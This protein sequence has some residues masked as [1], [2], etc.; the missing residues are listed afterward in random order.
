MRCELNNKRTSSHYERMKRKDHKATTSPLE[1]SNSRRKLNIYISCLEAAWSHVGVCWCV[2]WSTW[3][4]LLEELERPRTTKSSSQTVPMEEDPRNEEDI[5]DD[6]LCNPLMRGTGTRQQPFVTRVSLMFT[7]RN[8]NGRDDSMSS[9]SLSSIEPRKQQRQDS[10]SQQPN[11]Q[12]TE[13]PH[14]LLMLLHQ[15]DLEIKGL[16]STAQRD[17]SDRLGCILQELVKSRQKGSLKRSPNQEQLQKEVE[18]LNSELAAI[19]KSH[20]KEMQ[21][22]ED[23][24]MK[25]QL[26]VLH[27]QET[28]KSLSAKSDDDSCSES[29]I[30]V[31]EGT[32]L[33]RE[34][35]ELWSESGTKIFPER[36]DLTLRRIPKHISF[37]D[38]FHKFGSL[39]SSDEDKDDEVISSIGSVIGKAHVC[40][41]TEESSLESSLP[42]SKQLS[43]Q[44]SAILTS[45][46]SDPAS[47]STDTKTTESSSSLPSSVEKD[48]PGY[49]VDLSHTLD[50]L[51]SALP[52]LTLGHPAEGEEQW[53]P[54]VHGTSIYHTEERKRFPAVTDSVKIVGV[55]RKG[56]FVRILNALFNKEVDLSGYIIQQWVG[57]CPVSIYRFPNGTILPAHHHITVWAAGANLPGKKSSD[58]ADLWKFFKAGPECTTI[59][60]DCHGQTVSQYVAPHRFTAAAEAYNDNVDLSVDKFPLY[61][62][63]EKHDVSP[64][65]RTVVPSQKGN[66]ISTSNIMMQRRHTRLFS[67]D[68]SSSRMWNGRSMVIKR[69]SSSSSEAIGSKPTSPKSLPPLSVVKESHSSISEEG[70]FACPTWQPFLEEPKAREFKTTLDTTLPMVALIGQKSAR[71]KYGFKHMTYVPTTTDLHL[72]RYCPVT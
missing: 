58:K 52:S 64:S 63:E 2:I 44:S 65:S 5:E 23:K 53:V 27:L 36:S 31:D 35:F 4:A 32:Q 48:Q 24:L 67:V 51:S 30:S 11:A 3:G 47:T 71:S 42:E 13:N 68:S 54:F 39:S 7:P 40:G 59:L 25:S 55:H 1:S 19:K 37:V 34:S 22:L 66:L 43:E 60:C 12:P 8:D 6:V 62:D 45:P 38:A 29:S 9:S 16:K 15:K 28:V 41:T 56:K 18:Q 50:S 20:M 70:Y 10:T 72:R 61:E 21:Q 69:S 26:L 57:G 33:A 17:P 46:K 49:S 14:I